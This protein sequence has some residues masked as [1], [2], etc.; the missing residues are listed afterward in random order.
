LLSPGGSYFY[1]SISI[2]PATTTL[3][4]GESVSLNSTLPAGI[5]LSFEANPVRISPGI[6]RSVQMTFNVGQNVSPGDYQ[7]TVGGKSGSSSAVATVTLHVVQYLVLEQ[8][9]LFVPDSLTVKAGST[10]YWINLDAPAGGDPEVHNVSFT[11]GVTAQSPAM[12]QYATFSQTFSAAGTYKYYC[13]FHPS[14]M[15]GTITVTSG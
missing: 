10:V 5:T 1:P 15:L 7:V 6:T 12:T 11:S 14:S 9:N 4:S 8:G 13:T 2:A 3:T